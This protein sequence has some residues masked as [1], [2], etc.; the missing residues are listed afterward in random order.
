MKIDYNSVFLRQTER[1]REVVRGIERVAVVDI[2]ITTYNR[3]SLLRRTLDSIFRN[4]T[5]PFRLFIVD[6]CSSD[7]TGDYLR[8]LYDGRLCA[9]ILNKRRQGV[10][11]GLN[12]LYGVSNM[13][14]QF[15][16]PARYFAYLQDDVEVK[17]RWIRVLI[18]AYEELQEKYPIGFF[19]GFDSP[20]HHPV[21]A[22]SW[23]GRP[24]EFKK[25][26]RAAC[27]VAER[28]FW[29]SIMPIPRLNPDGTER[30]MPSRGR[31]SRVDY[32][33]IGDHERWSAR[34]SCVRQGK[35]VMV[36]PGLVTH[37]GEESRYS[38]WRRVRE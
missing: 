22:T 15:Y 30:G 28:G 11:Y 32:Y 7:G 17:R 12:V 34:N 24:V 29:D 3:C 8:R 36:V 10:C 1:D 31:G 33:L 19:G 21:D 6:D 37:M 13:F 25:L 2:G 18:D 16:T 20:E 26:E 5:V 23:R 4:T 9:V 35:Y 14:G 38:T 27:L